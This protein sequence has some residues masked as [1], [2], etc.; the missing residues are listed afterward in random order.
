MK[1]VETHGL[2]AHLVSVLCVTCLHHFFNVLGLVPFIL[3][4]TKLWVKISVER[5]HKWGWVCK[6]YTNKAGMKAQED[7][8]TTEKSW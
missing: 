7:Y 4:Y 6:K 1:T 2:H 3:F 5:K 8:P